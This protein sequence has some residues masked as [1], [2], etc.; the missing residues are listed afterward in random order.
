ML[1]RMLPRKASN[2][3]KNAEMFVLYAQF[4]KYPTS[5][6]RDDQLAFIADM[7]SEE[8]PFPK[9]VHDLWRQFYD[10]YPVFAPQEQQEDVMVKTMCVWNTLYFR[11]IPTPKRE[12][13]R[14]SSCAIE[15]LKRKIA[16]GATAVQLI[17]PDFERIPDFERKLTGLIESCVKHEQ[18]SSLEL[19]VCAC[20]H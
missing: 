2:A 9:E 17:R 16:E 7:L 3:Q 5:G 20:V 19:Q 14:M 4:P 1:D 11:S 12:R 13:R 18:V 6:S 10:E 8:P 15:V